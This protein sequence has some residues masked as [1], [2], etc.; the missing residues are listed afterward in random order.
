MKE[1]RQ[2]FRKGRPET[3]SI[4]YAVDERRLMTQAQWRPEWRMRS[5]VGPK[6]G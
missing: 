4:G 6:S 1:T 2:S 3:T 5:G